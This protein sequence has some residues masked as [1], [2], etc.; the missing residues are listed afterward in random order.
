MKLQNGAV[1]WEALLFNKHDQVVSKY[2][3]PREPSITGEVMHPQTRIP[4]L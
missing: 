4:F 3:K 2:E 1:F